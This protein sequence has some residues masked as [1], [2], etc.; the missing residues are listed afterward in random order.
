M[1]LMKNEREIELPNR[2]N[3]TNE[4]FFFIAFAQVYKWLTLLIICFDFI[5]GYLYLL[6]IH[7]HYQV[8]NLFIMLLSS[9]GLDAVKLRTIW[10]LGI[11]RP[12]RAKLHK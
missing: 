3:M 5:L 9:A 6:A 11:Y 1:D 8:V 12:R 2:K 4:Q 10:T 7:I